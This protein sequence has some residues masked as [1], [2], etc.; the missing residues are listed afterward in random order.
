MKTVLNGKKIDVNVS[1]ERLENL[2]G[3][4]A[5]GMFEGEKLAGD[6][7]ALDRKLDGEI[8][9]LV[10]NRTIA[11]KFKQAQMISTL[12]RIKTDRIIVIGMGKKKEFNGERMRKASAIAVKY[13]RSFGNGCAI[14]VYDNYTQA[15]VEGALLGLYRFLRYKKPE[16]DSKDITSL[17]FV[18]GK[19]ADMEK[20]III[21]ESV[22]YA[23]DLT[24]TPAADMTPAMLAEEAK[25][26]A[27][28]NG[29]KIKV[30]GKNEIQKMGMNSFAAVAKGSVQEPKFIV[31]ENKGSGRPI[32]IIG[33]GITFDSGGLD[34]KPYPYMQGMKGDKAGA[35]AVIALM[36]AASRLKIRQNVIGIIPACENMPSGSAY[37]TGDI[38]SAM[39]KKTIEVISTDAEGRLILADALSYA[40][41]KY[42]P[43]AI[44]DLATLTGACIVALGYE[45]AAVMGNNKALNEKIVKA[46][47]ECF[48]RVWELPLWDEYKEKVKSDIA[49]VRNVAK[50]RGSEAGTIEGAAFLDAFVEK[51]KWAHLD[52]AGVASMPEPREY[53]PDG[54]TGYGVRLI[55]QL[56]NDW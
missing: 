37:K 19:R 46:G 4:V 16:K 14:A 6:L 13:A 28:S 44:I 5:V 21:S 36:A 7:L 48:E 39:N 38:I 23:R 54:A 10:K 47:N 56:L 34:I 53:T 52:I 51:A 42:K 32:I 26:T 31:M 22:N 2:K 29:L 8:S 49:D 33:K 24:N 43:E 40:E 41:R 55:I 9:R 12:G 11:G 15:A 27:R 45:A 3:T 50:G 35:C 30:Y 20:G 18:N 25:K 17:V 1:S